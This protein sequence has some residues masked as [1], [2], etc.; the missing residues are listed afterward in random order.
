MGV[1]GTRV[2]VNLTYWSSILSNDQAKPMTDTFVQA[3][4]AIL[5]CS[6]DNIGSIDIVSEAC[7]DQAIKWNSILPGSVDNLFFHPIFNHARH[8]PE[9]EAVCAWDGSFTYGEV[10]RLSSRLAHHLVRLGLTRGSIVPVYMEKSRWAVIAMLGV[11]K[12]GGALATLDVAQPRARLRDVCRDSKA[13]FVLASPDSSGSALGMAPNNV[14]VGQDAS[15]TWSADT[16]RFPLPHLT[17]SSPAYVIFTSGST[18]R[19]KGSVIDHRGLASM[20]HKIIPAV[21]LD[22]RSR[23][24]QFASYVFDVSIQEN[25]VTLCAGGCVCIPSERQR[26]D[27]LVGTM[28]RMRVNFA[29]FTPSLMRILE[30]PSL[31]AIKTVVMGGEAPSPQDVQGWPSTTRIINTYGPSECTIFCVMTD[32]VPEDPRVIGKAL[33]CNT[34]IVDR[35]D[36]RKLVPIGAVGELVIEG[37]SVSRAGYINDPETT[38]AA[39]VEYPSWLS[40]LRDGRQE[41]LYRS[42]D[43]AQYTA[44]GSIRFISRKDNQVKVRGQRIELGEVEFHLL[45]CFPRAVAIVAHLL[46]PKQGHWGKADAVLAAFVLQN[47]DGHSDPNK[48][49][50]ILKDPTDSFRADVAVAENQ[51]RQLVPAYMIPSTF[52]PVNFSPKSTSFK[53]DRKALLEVASNLSQQALYTYNVAGCAKRQAETPTEKRIQ[54]IVA[55]ILG[56]PKQ[57]IGMDDD[58]FRLGGDS[59]VAMRMV[60][61]A[62]Q[63]GLDLSVADIFRHPRIS[64]LAL[65]AKSAKISSPVVSC[66]LLKSGHETQLLDQAIQ[67][68]RVR[69]ANVQ[70]V[71][72]TTQFQREWLERPCVHLAIR[73]PGPVATQ[74]LKAAIRKLVECHAILRTVFVPCG[75]SVVQ[76]VLREIDAQLH[77][78]NVD[79]SE[80][81]EIHVDRLVQ[82]DAS[83][84]LPWGSVPFKATLIAKGAASHVLV[85]RL[86]HAQYDGVAK[87]KLFGD[88]EKAY[89]GRAISVTASYADYL[90]HRDHQ[91]TPEALRFWRNLL[92]SSG[93]TCLS[94]ARLGGRASSCNEPV[95]LVL[96]TRH[97]KASAV[98]EGITIATVFK[99]AWAVVLRQLTGESDVVFSQVVNGRS[100][101]LTDVDLVCGTC[102]NIVPVRA[103]MEAQW[104]GSRLFKHLQEQHARML[105]FETVDFQDIVCQCTD[106]PASSRFGS[107]VQHQNV[108]VDPKLSLA[109]LACTTSTHVF[110]F[111]PRDLLVESSPEPGDSSSFVVRLVASTQ[112]VS[113]SGADELLERLDR[114]LCGLLEFPERELTG[115]GREVVSGS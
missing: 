75:G 35:R 96:R 25:L 46:S 27:D 36:H 15:R 26:I 76:V 50:D 82:R 110:D 6:S 65:S 108:D 40:R 7:K 19:P 74:N 61:K 1:D 67:G 20:T 68:H 114:V 43:L 51:L 39:F 86:Y 105:P 100:L 12:A 64:Q 44:D 62:R 79:E 109:G 90:S 23:A 69:R 45:R 34:W 49:G 3:L 42:G 32:Y 52:L 18:G 60:S 84:A 94:P 59:I 102:I 113:E 73:I 11:L 29:N 9:A 80:E 112:M 41:R 14:V 48:T 47:A 38:A 22:T 85:L 89:V 95:S 103:A 107:V 93:V 53:I 99:A 101:P 92:E 17:P 10:G 58:F 21:G 77:V 98:P 8:R 2:N 24:F 71:L 31:D 55:Q 4:D 33:G 63:E 88:L 66:S 16:S 83:R 57:M 54:E 5:A 72:P 30:G 115:L 106:W 104:T 78:L 56:Q 97:I 70:D 28:A 81:L 37:P 87:S 13:T 91:K 111:I